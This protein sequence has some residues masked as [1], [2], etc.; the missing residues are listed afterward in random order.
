MNVK[1]LLLENSRY[2]FQLQNSTVFRNGNELQFP[3]ERGQTGH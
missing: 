3:I 2:L 1:G